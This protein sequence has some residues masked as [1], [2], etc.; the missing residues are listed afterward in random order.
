MSGDLSRR[1]PTQG[2]EDDFDQLIDNLN[3]MLDQIQT[4]MEDV[5]RVSDNIAHD[6][7]TPLARLRNRL[8]V[9]KFHR[10]ATQSDQETVN[11]AIA[12]ADGLLSTFNALLR[13][14]RI[15]SER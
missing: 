9:L 2:T 11:E 7:K 5:R 1:I 12:D 10:S 3:R 13:I 14:A 6:L 4:L 8:E 15:E